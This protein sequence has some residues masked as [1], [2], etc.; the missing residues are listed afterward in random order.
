MSPLH[1]LRNTPITA[2]LFDYGQVLSFPASAEV[3]AR[4]A[5][6]LG[7]APDAFALAYYERRL[8]YDRGDLSA[9]AYWTDL[10]RR[11]RPGSVLAS[12]QLAM[13]RRWDID[14]W[15]QTEPRMLGWLTELRAAGFRTGL[16]SN[17][18][19][20]LIVHFRAEGAWI[21]LFDHLTFSQE[22]GLIKPEPEIYRHS[23][24]GLGNAAENV[25]FI[26]DRE[27]NVATAREL[28]MDGICFRST[29][30]LRAEL[31]LRAFSVLP[32]SG[33]D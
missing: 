2:V 18:P 17:M 8:A 11:A 30:G 19:E 15:N 29:P 22:V 27:E 10:A 13:L 1:L 16:L 3:F 21:Q 32:A 14:M 31:V 5:R 4:M 24:R 28:G 6:L 26:D 12:E 9:E 7:H 23:L 33:G 25:L 20:D